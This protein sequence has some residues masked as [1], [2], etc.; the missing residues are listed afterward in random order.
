MRSRHVEVER[1]LL[2]SSFKR[3]SR[4]LGRAFCRFSCVGWQQRGW[5]QRRVR[6]A[7]TGTHW[8]ISRSTGWGRRSVILVGV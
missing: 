1:L 2:I 8:R 7:A 6:S 4:P 3:R 5:S